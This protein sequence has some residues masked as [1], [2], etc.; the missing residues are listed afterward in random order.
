MKED[1]DDDD[2]D[3]DAIDDSLYENFP[4]PDQAPHGRPCFMTYDI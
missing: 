2:A 1:D 4:T 3:D